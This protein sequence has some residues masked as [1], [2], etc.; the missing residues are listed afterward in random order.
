MAGLSIIVIGVTIALGVA[1]IVAMAMLPMR[2]RATLAYGA[3]AMMVGIYVGFAIIG[4]EPMDTANRAE[5]SGLLVEAIVAIGFLFGGL[6]V[7]NS[8]KPWILG[9]LILAHGGVD[10]LHLLANVEY[11]PDWYEFLCLI[12]DA[13]VGA[14]AIWLL[15]E[16]STTN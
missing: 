4:L 12:F 5:W 15:S 11:S 13:I 2:G 6:M 14:G 10:L 16:K 3:L 8:A 9:A 1:T 7:L